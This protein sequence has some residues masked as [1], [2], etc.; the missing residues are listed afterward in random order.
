MD[1]EVG[2]ETADDG[3]LAG[4]MGRSTVPPP[5]LRPLLKPCCY[6][7]AG[8]WAAFVAWCR[9]AGAAS[10][11]AAPATVATYL[12]SLGERLSAPS[13]AGAGSGRFRARKKSRSA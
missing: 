13:L 6:S 4:D 2:E 7:D 12:V 11:P 8:D 3:G 5:G 1:A 10:L 9:L